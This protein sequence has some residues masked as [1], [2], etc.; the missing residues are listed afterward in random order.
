M[1]LNM[2]LDYKDFDLSILL[3]DK[4]APNGD[5]SNGFNSG[6]GGNGLQYVA[7]N[8]FTLDNTNAELPMISPVGFGANNSDFYYHTTTMAPS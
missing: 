4:A 6:A 8:S 1:A 7:L 3:P 2:G 5:S